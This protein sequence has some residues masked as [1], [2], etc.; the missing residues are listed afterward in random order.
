MEV[1]AGMLAGL[2]ERSMGLG[3]EWKV[4][5]AWFEKKGDA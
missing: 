4:S 3:A 2:F 1:Q 5:D